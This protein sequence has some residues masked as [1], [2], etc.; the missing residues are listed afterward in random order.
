[1]ERA[2]AAID[3]LL[4]NHIGEMKAFANPPQAVSTITKVIL[5]MFGEKITANDSD[6]KIWKKGQ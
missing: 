1:M 4:K 6:E 2:K 3:C 5:I